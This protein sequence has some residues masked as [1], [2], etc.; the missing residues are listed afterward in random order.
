MSARG[1]SR[2][3][4]RVG[5]AAEGFLD[6]RF[7]NALAEFEA[8]KV[9]P[10]AVGPSI[11]SRCV[12]IGIKSGILWVLVPNHVWLTEMTALKRKLIE[13]L[14]IKLGRTVV[15]DIKFKVGVPKRSR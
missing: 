15:K 2:K 7:G 6:S 13:N 11:A 9:W 8:V 3:F 1:R 5:E 4:K 14:K 10:E 12:A